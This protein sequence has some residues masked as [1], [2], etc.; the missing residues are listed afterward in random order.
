M[1]VDRSGLAGAAQG[2]SAYLDAFDD[3]LLV[4]GRRE[5]GIIFLTPGRIEAG[6]GFDLMAV[7][8]SNVA[9]EALAKAAAARVLGVM[10]NA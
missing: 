1:V 10:E 8:E 6:T 7:G 2:I 9:A 5:T 4:P 3:L